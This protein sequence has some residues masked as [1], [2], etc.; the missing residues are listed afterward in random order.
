MVLGAPCELIARDLI[1]YG[2]VEAAEWVR[3]CSDDDLV[4][5]C[6]V[7]D[8]LLLHGPSTKAG[9]SMM[10][11]KALALAT[12][13]IREGTPRDLASKR[14]KPL[15]ALSEAERDAIRRGRWVNY[16]LQEAKPRDYGV[17]PDARD[18][19]ANSQ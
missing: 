19:W 5:I 7:A 6:S 9:S 13:Y 11:A 14:R 4:R 10:I 17:G 18:Y 16:Q 2:E 1:E 12:V 3:S 8:W 15:P